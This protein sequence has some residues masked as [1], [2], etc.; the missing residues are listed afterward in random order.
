VRDAEGHLKALPLYQRAVEID[1]EFA[2]AHAWLGRMYAGIG[3]F[4]L[5]IESAGKAWRYRHRA[6]DHER[7]YIDF[8]Y[9]RQVKGGLEKC[10]Q[11]CE[12]YPRDLQPHGF[13][14]GSTS[15]QVGKFERAVEE[16][17]KAIA[18]ESDTA[19]PW[20][21]V[22]FAYVILDK[23]AEAKAVLQK[24][25]DRKLAIPEMLITRYQI[26]F[27]ENDQQELARLTQAG[28]KRSPTF[29]EQEA[30]VAGYGGQLR[31]AR[32]LSERGVEL[33]RQG[34]RLERAAQDQAGA[35][36][37]ESLFS[38]ASRH[39]GVRPDRGRFPLAA[40]PSLRSGR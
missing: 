4:T 7:F 3:E 37:R 21:N 11:I 24:A 30:H 33:A 35:A 19:I 36:I 26:A 16:G 9:Y 1:P 34:G 22:A 14:S 29:C 39:C 10:A 40:R 2:S 23:L 27:L 6:S 12:S 18:M 8:S 20:A 38:N 32:T 31:R 15:L 28:Y 13:L 25:A 17:Q 5:G